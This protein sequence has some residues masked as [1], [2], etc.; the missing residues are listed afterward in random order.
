MKKYINIVGKICLSMAIFSTC[1]SAQA[2]SYAAPSV[3]RNFTVYDLNQSASN[4]FA[5]LIIRTNPIQPNQPIYGWRIHRL[6]YP[7]NAVGAFGYTATLI[8][9]TDN[10]GK[11]SSAFFLEPLDS[12]CGKYTQETYAVG[13]TRGLKSTPLAFNVYQ[14]GQYYP[15]SHNC[16][17]TPY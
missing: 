3:Y 9:Y 1:Y 13:S 4:N 10:N 5:V 6:N 17:E 11:Y 12:I 2:Q 16:P 14:S 8:G 15:I 7:Y